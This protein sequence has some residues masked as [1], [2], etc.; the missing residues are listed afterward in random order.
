MKNNS[1]LTIAIPV[2]NRESIVKKTLD[3]IVSQS[4]RPLKII[5]VDNNSKDNTLITL[6]KWREDYNSE[7]FEITILT[8]PK[9]GA[10]AARN[11]ALSVIDTEWTMFFDSDDTM[12]SN[13]I[14]KV[15]DSISKNP[16]LELIGWGSKIHFLNKRLL[17]KPFKTKYVEYNNIMHSIFSTQKYVAKTHLFR[18]AGGW[19]E[20]LTMG[21]DIELA[22]RLLLQKPIIGNISNHFVDIFESENSITNDKKDLSS[23]QKALEKVRNTLPDDKRHWIDLQIIIQ[24]ATWARNDPKSADI[25]AGIIESATAPRRFLWKV[26]YN[27]LKRGGRGVAKLYA[28]FHLKGMSI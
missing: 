19:D 11:K 25:V 28:L 18:A 10:C 26:F 14:E 9:P 17:V 23:I 27:Y 4:Y 6:K 13:H 22:S 12:P 15:I 2:Y 16:E 7:D 8:E 24:G 3:S 5:L 20:D 21:D 1:L